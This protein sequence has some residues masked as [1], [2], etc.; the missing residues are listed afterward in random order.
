MLRRDSGGPKRGIAYTTARFWWFQWVTKKWN[1][2]YYGE[3]MLAP[4]NDQK[5]KL[6]ILRWD[7]GGW[8]N[9]IPYTTAGSWFFQWT[10][11]KWNYRC[12]GEILGGSEIAEIVDNRW[13]HWEINEKLWKR[14]KRW[15][16]TLKNDEK[17]LKIDETWWKW[18][19]SMTNC[20]KVVD[21]ILPR[22]KD[23][24]WRVWHVGGTG[25]H[26]PF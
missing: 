7:P 9:R 25:Y 24:H 5:V 18:W 21:L 19:N 8:K 26:C 23:R 2:L 20:L 4:M 11:K 13:K 22:H 10:C 6:S 12:Y 16:N 1:R 3:I 15:C 17:T 14:M